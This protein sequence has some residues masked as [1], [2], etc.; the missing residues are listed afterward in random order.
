MSNIRK[1]F[2]FII[3]VLSISM[4]PNKLLSSDIDSKVY[5]LL[6]KMTLKEKIG[7]MSQLPIRSILTEEISVLTENKLD[8]E[9]AKKQIIEK[10]VGSFLNIAGE[11]SQ[12]LQSIAVNETR[13]GIPLIFGMD[14]VHGHALYPGATVFPM[15]LG[16][17]SSWDPDIMERTAAATAAESVATGIKWTFAPILDVARDPRWGRIIEG[18]GEDPYLTSL[19]GSAKVRG[20]QGKNLSSDNSVLATAKHFVAYS[21]TVGGR[22]YSPSD[23]SLR[24]LVDIFMRPFYAVTKSGVGSIMTSFNEINGIPATSNKYLLRDNLKDSW[25]FDGFV[26]SDWASVGM[27]YHTHFVAKDLKEAAKLAIEAG[28]DMEMTSEAYLKHLEDLVLEGVV[29]ENLV[30]DA[31]KRILTAKMKLGLFDKPFTK[32][33]EKKLNTPE[34]RDLALEA[35]NKTLVLLKNNGVLPLKE[36]GTIAVI[37]P[38][39]DDPQNQLGGWTNKQ[40]EENVVTI[41]DGIK[42]IVS[43]DMDVKYEMG[44]AITDNVGVS[45]TGGVSALE[46]EVGTGVDTSIEKAVS[47][48][49]DSD[50]AVLVLGEASNMSSEPN[51]RTSLDLPGKQKELLKAVH[52]TGTPVVLVL[53]NGRPLT[54]NWASENVPAILETWFPGVE[55][56]NAVAKALFGKTNPSGKLTIT[57]PK[58]IGQVPLW[59]NHHPQ[60]NW[61]GLENFG[62]RYIDIE[63]T[64]LYPFGY[65]LSYT[66]FEY[67]DLDIIPTSNNIK[68]SFNVK[69]IG[70]FEGEETV[71]V[72]F[73]DKIS[74]IVTPD[75]Q[76]LRFKKVNI[77]PGKEQRITFD[78]SYDD[79]SLLNMEYTRVTEPGEFDILVGASS[80]EIILNE[81]FMLRK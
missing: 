71:Q 30:D 75:K 23:I 24:T 19:L 56:G 77:K 78:V 12:I 59:Y 16:L 29:S 5:D 70:E 50:I 48:A 21:E 80:E 66:R 61:E 63:D 54:I 10:G 22:D 79:F 45:V 52:A 3:I 17:S 68:I 81:S 31:V 39:A 38:L 67:S 65:G 6:N 20:Y 57:F 76:L 64:P 42:N 26:V 13:L 40:P 7:Q 32:I 74:S 25:G 2:C 34:H 1:I 4:L 11:N 49:K 58:N 46:L 37:G 55:G 28:V 73:S 51:S 41:L 44:C 35:A 15:P 60:K 8:I 27:L 9:K 14:A 43:A 36:K 33:D 69:N 72:Y 53:I 62:T 47:L 18:F